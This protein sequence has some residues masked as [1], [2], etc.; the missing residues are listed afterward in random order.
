M[1]YISILKSHLN[2]DKSRKIIII[3]QIKRINKD[4]KKIEMDI[5]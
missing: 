5:E 1:N 2:C 4:Q 3:Y